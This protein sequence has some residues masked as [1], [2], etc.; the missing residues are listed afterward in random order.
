MER[1]IRGYKRLVK[2]NLLVR[3][4]AWMTVGH[5]VRLAFQAIY[6]V[7]IARA[8]GAMSYGAFVGAVALVGIVAPFASWGTGFILVK[9]VARSRDAFGS[10]W[11]ASL[12]MTVLS[13][14]FFLCLLTPIS[15]MFW[16]TSVP[17]ELI[18]LVGI[19]DMI[20]VRI[21]DLAA[22]AFAAIELLQRSAEVYIVLSI[23]RA[24]SAGYLLFV[25]R[26]SDSVSWGWLYLLSASFAAMYSV[27]S[28]NRLIGRPVL[29]LGCLRGQLKDGFYFAVSQASLTLH[30]DV[31]KTMLV[32][33]AGLEATG[34]YGAAYRLVDVSF[35]PVSALV[36]SS[37]ARFF[38]HG[39]LGLSEAM[40]F[41]KRL[42]NYSSLYGLAA[43]GLLLMLSPFLPR[44]LGHDF[45]KS[46]VALRWLSPIVLIRAVHYFLA[47]SLSGSG[48]QGSRTLAQLAIVVLNIFLN[49]WLMPL[50]S[51]RGAAWSSLACDG[52]L[53][54]A[55]FGLIKFWQTR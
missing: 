51:W 49:L 25:L 53:V 8:L 16:S 48:F 39:R 29:R 35:A 5:G 19:S 40:R 12:V 10:Y 4:T 34:I 14:A 17:L 27:V 3:N 28:V 54:L 9:E 33:F 13:G 44:A 36:Y 23:T 1:L 24:L 2:E 55:L 22:Q 37:L 15:H 26:T 6:F 18:I 7:L 47:N 30:N 52:G 46:S 38:R 21:V 31:D 20:V 11:G 41:A 50:Y 43:V 32:K 42:I 45:A